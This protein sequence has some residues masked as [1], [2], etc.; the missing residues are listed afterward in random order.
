MLESGT[1]FYMGTIPTPFGEMDA[2]VFN[3]S[4]DIKNPKWV[5]PNGESADGVIK[6]MELGKT[7]DG[8]PWSD[9][10]NG[11]FGGGN[12][13]LS[14]WQWFLIGLAVLVIIFVASLMFRFLSFIPKKQNK[15]GN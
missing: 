10:W 8:D 3:M 1:S 12:G 9:F 6:D 13:G 2:I 11:I 4:N 15:G 7:L 14:I 5:L